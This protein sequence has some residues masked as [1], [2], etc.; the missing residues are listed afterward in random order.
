MITITDA[1]KQIASL[2][3]DL[4]AEALACMKAASVG[5]PALNLRYHRLVTVAMETPD[6]WSTA[7]RA[8]MLALVE[9]DTGEPE[10]RD[11]QVNIRLTAS[12]RATIAAAASAAGETMTGYIVRAAM[13]RSGCSA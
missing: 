13:E 4:A 1:C 11:R 12:E 3:G 9:L 8:A 10:R 2:R 5:S 7:D 6:L